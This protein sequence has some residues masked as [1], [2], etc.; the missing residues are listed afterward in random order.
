M[1]N[2]SVYVCYMWEWVMWRVYWLC[3]I[4]TGQMWIS[5]L[6]TV[7]ALVNWNLL[8]H[9][10]VLIE[11]SEKLFP[12]ALMAVGYTMDIPADEYSVQWTAQATPATTPQLWLWCLSSQC[13]INEQY[14]LFTYTT[15]SLVQTQPD[16]IHT[17]GLKKLKWIIECKKIIYKA[18]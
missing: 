4:E 9:C 2:S 15:Y 8:G 10:A 7:C 5:I 14:S 17:I 18:N 11:N 13:F 12:I 6:W 3:L 16:C 1:F